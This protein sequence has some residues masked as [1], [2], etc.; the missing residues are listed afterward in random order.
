MD[1]KQAYALHEASRSRKNR[2]MAKDKQKKNQAFWDFVTQKYKFVVQEFEQQ[3]KAENENNTTDPIHTA[4]VP[5]I[6]ASPN[7]P[8]N[9]LT[10]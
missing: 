1:K 5:P 7:R 10:T 9:P 3:Y 8:Q 6:S 2:Q 4:T